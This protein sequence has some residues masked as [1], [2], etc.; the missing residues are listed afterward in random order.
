MVHDTSSRRK[1]GTPEARLVRLQALGRPV[2][3]AL[4]GCGS[5]KRFAPKPAR[6]LYESRLFCAAVEHAERTA[7]EFWILSA[8]HGLLHPDKEVEPYDRNLKSLCKAERECWA[9][10]VAYSL[11]TVYLGLKVELAIYAG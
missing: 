2:K 3:V 10:R 6:R 11:A 1:V 7:D 9:S 8:F 5:W 4:I